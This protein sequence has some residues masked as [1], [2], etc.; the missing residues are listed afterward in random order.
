MRPWMS[1]LLCLISGVP[2]WTAPEFLEERF[3][4]PPGLR[5]YRVAGPELTGGSYALCFDGE[6]R[7]WW[8]MAPRFGG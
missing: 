3:E 6:G 7:F 5:I 4:L 2:A 8:V 1:L